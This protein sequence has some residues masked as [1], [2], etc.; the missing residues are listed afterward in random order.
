[1]SGTRAALVSALST[2]AVVAAVAGTWRVPAAEVATGPAPSSAHPRHPIRLTLEPRTEGDRLT[3]AV[4]LDRS[5]LFADLPATLEIRLPA[6]VTLLR[7]ETR[8]VLPPGAVLSHVVELSIAGVPTEDIVATVE[9]RG[10][11]RTARGQARHRFGREAPRLAEPARLPAAPVRGG[12]S[13]GTR[14]RVAP[15]PR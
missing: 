15:V 13:L 14:I 9:L 1:M 12:G 2:I 6:G 7:G 11:G 3:L 8:A 5:A 10:E 4:L